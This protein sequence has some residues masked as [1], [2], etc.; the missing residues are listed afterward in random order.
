M[1]KRWQCVS[2]ITFFSDAPIAVP[3]SPY[4][5]FLNAVNRAIVETY[6]EH[7]NYDVAMLSIDH[8][9]FNRK[10]PLGRFSIQRRE[11]TPFSE[12]KYYSDAPLPTKVHINLLKQFESDLLGLTI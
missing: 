9:T 12:N 3:K 5:N 2:Q 6:K 7:L 10:Y 4:K 8:D 1:V 11:N